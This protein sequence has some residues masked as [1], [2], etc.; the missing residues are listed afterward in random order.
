MAHGK[1]GALILQG[2]FSGGIYGAAVAGGVTSLSGDNL[3]GIT[4]PPSQATTVAQ[5][6]GSS[7]LQSQGLIPMNDPLGLGIPTSYLLFGGALLVI[8]MV[9]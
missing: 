7:V 1:K 8:L 5:A 9:T 2:L 6:V 4:V 3:P